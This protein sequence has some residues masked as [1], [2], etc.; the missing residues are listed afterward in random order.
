MNQLKGLQLPCDIAPYRTLRFA[1]LSRS[2]SRVKKKS[3]RTFIVFSSLVGGLTATSALLLYMAP[4]P[5]RPETPNSLSATTEISALDPIF[6]TARRATDS[7]WKYIYIHQSR[8][9]NGGAASTGLADHFI[10]GNGTGCGDGEIQY[11]PRW[12]KQEPAAPPAG[13]SEIDP[14]CITICVIGNFDRTT[15]TP[16]QL[17]RLTQLISA[18][19]S[20]L[21][22]P[23]DRVL[24]LDGQDSAAGTGRYFPITSIREQLR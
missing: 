8:T 2:V 24:S 15:P 9:L 20:K 7:R 1:S 13:A 5:L 11:T 12:D 18:L 3:K 6:Q 21:D 22:I 10:I 23:A 19:R 16:A 17:K 14:A 4:A